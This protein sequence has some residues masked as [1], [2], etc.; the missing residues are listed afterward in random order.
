VNQKRRKKTKGLTL[1]PPTLKRLLLGRRG[2]DSPDEKTPHG[3]ENESS[4]NSKKRSAV[5]AGNDPRIKSSADNRK[6][7]SY[8]GGNC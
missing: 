1:L 7:P 4:S 6:T 5:G 3:L 8:K 2:D